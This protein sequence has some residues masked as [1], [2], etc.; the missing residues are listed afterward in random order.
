LRDTILDR[1]PDADVVARHLH[2]LEFLARH[3]RDPDV[4]RRESELLFAWTRALADYDHALVRDAPAIARASSPAES[5]LDSE[6][7]ETPNVSVNSPSDRERRRARQR[8]PE[9]PNAGL[10]RAAKTI[11]QLWKTLFFVDVPAALGGSDDGYPRDMVRA[12]MEAGQEQ[13]NLDPW[14]A[15]WTYRELR[16][17]EAVTQGERIA[18]EREGSPRSEK[19]HRTLEPEQPWRA[20][21]TP[22]APLRGW[23]DILDSLEVP[24]GERKGRQRAIRALNSATGGPIKRIRKKPEVNRGELLAWIEDIE[25][26]A[27]REAEIKRGISAMMQ[28][29]PAALAEH[30]LHPEKRP[31]ARGRQT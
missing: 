19:G 24:A 11:R 5:A 6:P 30:G 9:H 13:G 31:S 29:G 23:A 21:R 1:S 15:V 27:Q 25:G 22:G 7:Q 26:R 20:A 8:G 4:F 10:E 2:V 16:L 17:R 18:A 14:L 3:D 28:G 12:Q